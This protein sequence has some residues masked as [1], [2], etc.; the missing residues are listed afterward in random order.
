MGTAVNGFPNFFM[1]TGP[2]TVNGH[3]SLILTSENMVNYIIKIIKPILRKTAAVA[4]IR[5]GAEAKWSDEIQRD[6]KETGFSGCTSW[7]ID[8][9]G[10]NSI[11]YP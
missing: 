11:M 9:K 2:N 7:Y 4:E 5:A 8:E 3:N 1:V 6:L 10:H